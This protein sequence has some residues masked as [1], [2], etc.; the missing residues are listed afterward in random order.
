MITKEDK[1]LNFLS[2]LV[3]VGFVCTKEHTKGQPTMIEIVGILQNNKDNFFRVA[4]IPKFQ[5]DITHFLP[6]TST[7]HKNTGEGQSSSTF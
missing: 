4:I 7:C 5:L 2:H 6:S 1:D 3:M